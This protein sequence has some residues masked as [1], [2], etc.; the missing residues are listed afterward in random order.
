M[1]YKAFR[2]MQKQVLACASFDGIA[3]VAVYFYAD[4]D[5]KSEARRIC[6]I[7]TLP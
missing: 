1:E 5:L 2:A 3:P 6:L 7:Y 4:V